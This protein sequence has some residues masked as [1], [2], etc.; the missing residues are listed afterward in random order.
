MRDGVDVLGDSMSHPGFEEFW[1]SRPERVYTDKE[2][3]DRLVDE[4][5]DSDWWNETQV[6]SFS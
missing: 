5:W 1:A 6:S 2:C 3:K 4:T